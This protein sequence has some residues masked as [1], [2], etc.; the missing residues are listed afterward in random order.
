MVVNFDLVLEITTD[1]V[2]EEIVAL[3]NQL[4][5]AWIVNGIP[6]NSELDEE[7]C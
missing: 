4:L 5:I 7:H 2:N 1:I 6:V 3:M